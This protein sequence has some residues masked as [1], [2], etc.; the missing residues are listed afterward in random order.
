M[1]PDIGDE[2]L[3]EFP[4]PPGLQEAYGK[5]SMIVEAIYE[6]VLDDVAV[7]LARTNEGL[8][9]MYY[10]VEYT[11]HHIVKFAG[12]RWVNDL[13]NIDPDKITFFFFF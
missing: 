8:K 4:L 7:E 2:F 3:M 5:E 6:G 9:E 12:D 11:E 13:L 10:I 1:I